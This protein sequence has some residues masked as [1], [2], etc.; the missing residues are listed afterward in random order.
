[1]MSSSPDRTKIHQWFPRGCQGVLL[2]MRRFLIGVLVALLLIVS[3][4]VGV[5]VAK[6][7]DLM[8]SWQPDRAR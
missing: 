1:M 5:T 6:W 4:A 8:L 2:P 3:V 7:P